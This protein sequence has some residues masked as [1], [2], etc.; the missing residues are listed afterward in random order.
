[1]GKIAIITDV[2][3][4]LDYVSPK[5]DVPTLR[6]I[7]NFGDEHYVDG[8]DIFADEFYE[9]LQK[10]KEIPSTS[11]PTVGEAM[12]LLEDLISE[13]YSD[14]IMYSISY[15]LSSIGQM[16]ENIKAE[17]SEIASKINIFVVDTKSAAY[18]Q[19]FIVNVAKKMAL[20]G[21]GVSE[22]ISESY[23]LIEKSHAYFIVDNLNSL[24]KNGRLSGFAGF[25]GNILQIK[26]ILHLDEEGYI[27]VY[28][29]Q[30]THRKAVERAVELIKNEVQN[31]KKI[32]LFIF[33]TVRYDD[34]VSLKEI[35][36]ET[37]KNIDGEIEIHMI[38]PAVGAHI[39]CGIL[40]IGY[41][42][43]KE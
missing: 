28:E 34:A 12:T 21:F 14:V 20:E 24:V 26:P 9:K 32:K 1:M 7:I 15:K 3:A 33:H 8:K 31:E 6:S 4:G 19:G 17:E 25:V 41:F 27:K 39:G 10:S 35:F 11:A 30:K 43:M 22:I 36:S 42:I 38:T 29:K 13:G 37:L 23:R 5:L 18:M 2:N 16:V 40:G